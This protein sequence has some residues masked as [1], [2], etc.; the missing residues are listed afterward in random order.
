MAPMPLSDPPPAVGAACLAILRETAGD[1]DRWL[2]EVESSDDPRG[3]HQA[4][5]ALRRLRTA[6]DTFAPI[7]DRGFASQTRDTARRLFRILGDIRDADIR[8]AGADDAARAA[9]EI[10]A[11]AARQK[12]R[13][14]LDREGA[15]DFAACLLARIDGKGWKRG[16]D[17][18][19]ARRKAPVRPLALAALDRAW[20][21]I[22]P[23]EPLAAMSDKALHSLRKR[24][25]TLRYQTE[26]FGGIA[27][28]D[29]QASLEVMK[30]LQ[31]ALGLLTDMALGAGGDADRDR[32]APMAQARAALDRLLG[33][34]PW[35]RDG[36]QPAGNA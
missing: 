10:A 28:G 36:D 16:G 33:A 19:R 3:A 20:A 11:G 13:K 24:V 14:R 25:K 30:Q 9:Q 26:F 23:A 27:G 31:D 18:A 6:L 21:A 34:G 15:G 35:W 8:L 1:F 5:V 2:A 12:A 4:R 32:Q 22:Q 17:R 7:L 29:W